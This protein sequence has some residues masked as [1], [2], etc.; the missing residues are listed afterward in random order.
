[1]TF[2][3]KYSHAREHWRAYGRCRASAAGREGL[4]IRRDPGGRP[5]PRGRGRRARQFTAIMGPLRVRQV[6]A[7]ALP[8]RAG[9]RDQRA[10]LHR[11][12]RDHRAQGQDSSRSC[13]GTRSASSSRRSTCSRRSPRW[14]T[15]RCRWTSPVASPT[16]AWLDRVVETVGLA[17]RLK[18][19]PTQ[20]SGGQQQRGRRGP[21]ARRPARDHLRRRADR[22]P[23][24]ARRR[25]G[26]GLPA[27][28]R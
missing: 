1:M 21:R 3:R 19:R 8:G 12:H 11:R 7:D 2:G 20:L 22:E 28:A 15:S 16:S 23:R 4:R 25:R 24:L 13:A 26:A 27:P 14:R 17:G 6:H 10:G 5:R 18:H 9:H